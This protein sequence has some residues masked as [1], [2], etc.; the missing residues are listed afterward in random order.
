MKICIHL[1]LLKRPRID[2]KAV[3]DNCA[4]SIG[5]VLL[6]YLLKK[7]CLSLSSDVALGQPSFLLFLVLGSTIW[8]HL[9]LVC[10]TW[11]WGRLCTNDS[12]R[13]DY[14][15]SASSKATT[16]PS[17][18]ISRFH[19]LRSQIW[20]PTPT[21]WDL[22]TSEMVN[23][24]AVWW[25]CQ[26][27]SPQFRPPCF[28][29]CK[30]N[31]I[32]KVTSWVINW[33]TAREGLG[34]ATLLTEWSDVVP[35]NLNALSSLKLNAL[36]SFKL[37]MSVRH[38]PSTKNTIF[39]ESKTVVLRSLSFFCEETAASAIMTQ[40]LKHLFLPHAQHSLL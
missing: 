35:T 31:L 24:S 4:F 38:L 33:E 16:R 23:L 10:P 1:N 6:R 8:G 14:N 28:R 29:E 34:P 39:A 17:V 20:V 36:S 11:P 5:N 40:F 22:P 26:P 9:L 32:G 30:W 21:V 25:V 18:I 37:I 19:R 7:G 12:G 13:T 27:L 15:D 3:V 2:F